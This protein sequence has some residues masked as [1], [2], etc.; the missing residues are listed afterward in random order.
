MKRE[1]RAVVDRLLME[2]GEYIPLEFLLAEG[3]LDYREY[4]SWRA[5]EIPRLEQVLFGDQEL[6][7]TCLAEAAA[8]AKALGL[9]PGRLSYQGWGSAFGTKPSYSGNRVSEDRF[10]TAYRR[11]AQQGQMDLFIDAA[12]NRLVN[13]IVQSL[14]GRNYQ[15]ARRLLERLFE[16]D[17]GHPRL[18][19]LEQM[20]EAGNRLAEPVQ[21]GRQ[22]L[23]YLQRTLQP[24]AE[25]ELG[26]ES[27]SLLVPHWR[28]LTSA[29]QGRPF[30]P[31]QPEL[32]ASFTA[33][34]AFAWEDVL[35][36]IENE[37]D[38][39]HRP[40]LIGRHAAACG[41]LHREVAA[42][43]GWFHLCWAFPDHAQVIAH[44]AEPALRQAWREF[45][46]VDP[47]LAPAHF[48]AW[49]LLLRPGLARQ[50]TD[51]E[52]DSA[53]PPA[54]SLIYRLQLERSQ[55][56]QAPGKAT[57]ERRRQ[58]QALEPDLFTHYMRT[59]VEAPGAPS[60]S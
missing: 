7:S 55:S 36:A 54:F 32:H 43:Q 2:Q 50:L 25:R 11:P 57:V 20:I 4:E 29:L 42:L 27:S 41:R 52:S 39:R 47:E 58:L 17:P 10:H 26:R 33:I 31:A 49:L 53:C 16:A 51:P 9:E 60:G 34:G 8:Y 5:G 46:L 59:R 18:G 14:A 30:D 19:A 45:L 37:P 28:R 40:V 6:L 15:E 1:I 24:M 23:D 48:P 56:A 3:R 13:G 38:W 12:A 22:E 44:Q 21:D 35:A